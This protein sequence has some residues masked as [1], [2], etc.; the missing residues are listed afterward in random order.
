M[1]FRN[2]VD[3]SVIFKP[4]HLNLELRQMM[5]SQSQIKTTGYA[6]V[7]RCNE[8]TYRVDKMKGMAQKGVSRGILH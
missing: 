8:T 7:Y 1:I 2:F 4:F 3:E 5:T 6:K